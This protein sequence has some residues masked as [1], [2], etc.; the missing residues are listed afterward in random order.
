MRFLILLMCSI[1]ISA[2][3]TKKSTA[4]PTVTRNGDQVVITQ[5]AHILQGRLSEHSTIDVLFKDEGRAMGTFQGDAF[6]TTMDKAIADTLKAQYGDFFKCGDPG[7][8]PALQNMCT[9]VFV[10][11]DSAVRYQ[12]ERAMTIV[13]SGQIPVVSLTVASIQNMSQKWNG[14]DVQDTTGIQILF[15][16]E[17]VIVTETYI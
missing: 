11:A 6:V 10:A 5:G 1:L 4:I 16:I 14:M 7:V 15:V 12:L 9:Y 2:G 8:Q 17:C 13:R 3:C